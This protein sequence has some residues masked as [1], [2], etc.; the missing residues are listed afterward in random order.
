MK[1]DKKGLD[2]IKKF[3]GFSGKPYLDV[4]L[5]PTIGYGSTHY[6]NGK[7]VKL[8]DPSISKEAATY[9]LRTQVDVT[10]SKAVNHYVRVKITQ[11]QFDALVSFAYNL[12]TGALRSST[13][14]KKLNAGKKKRAG[15]EFEKWVHA[16]GKVRRG[17]VAR[18]ASEEKLFLA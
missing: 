12:G 6:N 7:P 8:S 14:L 16:G 1:I 13:L 5:V 4:A 9:L 18:R 10:Y 15:K 2:L 11:N 3:E 17:L